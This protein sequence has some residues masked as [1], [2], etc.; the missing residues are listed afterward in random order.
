MLASPSRSSAATPWPAPSLAVFAGATTARWCRCA[1]T[2]SPARACRITAEPPL[3]LPRSA[4]AGG[5]MLA[6]TT[7]V[8]QALERRIGERP[9]HWFCRRWPD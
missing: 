4:N 1:S 5:D 7:K 2:G 3:V 8:D 6:L 9:A